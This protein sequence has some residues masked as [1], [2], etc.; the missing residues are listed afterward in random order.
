MTEISSDQLKR[1]QDQWML[2]EG[3]V[4]VGVGVDE[5]RPCFKVYFS[6]SELLEKAPLPD[7]VEDIKVVKMVSGKIERQ[8]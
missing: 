1:F 4:A 2:F 5:E 6:N 3:V 7:N 8:S